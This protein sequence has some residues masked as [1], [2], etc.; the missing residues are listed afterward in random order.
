[1]AADDIILPD[2]TRVPRSLVSPEIASTY[3]SPADQAVL[4]QT[5]D[6]ALSSRF[7]QSAPPPAPAAWDNNPGAFGNNIAQTAKDVGLDYAKVLIN[8]LEA[9]KKAVAGWGDIAELGGQADKYLMEKTGGLLHQRLPTAEG[10]IAMEQKLRGTTPPPPGQPSDQPPP[11][12]PSNTPAGQVL[13]AALGAG[14]APGDSV[15]LRASPGI[16]VGMGSYADEK[17]DM[18]A[19]AGAEQ[20]AAQKL[21]DIAAQRA[22]VVAGEQQGRM[23]A[24]E[25]EETRRQAI[26]QRAQSIS[27]EQIQKA[28]TLQD[29]LRKMATVKVDPNHFWADKGTGDRMAAAFGVFLGGL[30]GGEN[31]ALG[32]L[33]RAIDRD[34]DAQKTNWDNARQIKAQEIEGQKNIYGMHLAAL[35]D[36]RAAEAGARAASLEMFGQRLEAAKSTFDSPEIKARAEAAQAAIQK[37]LAKTNMEL[38]KAVND[39]AYK[40]GTLEL[41]SAELGIRAQEANARAQAAA[42]EGQAKQMA[43]YVPGVGLALDEKSKEKVQEIAGAYNETKSALDEMRRLRKDAGGGE[44]LNRDNVKKMHVAQTAFIGAANRMQRFGSLDKGAQELLSL[45][46][47]GDITDFGSAVDGALEQA[48]TSLQ[49]S[50]Q[51]QTRPYMAQYEEAAKPVSSFVARK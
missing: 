45:L 12:G 18:S 14:G 15:S 17:R 24:M 31:Q 10:L 8:P 27:Q 28:A 30:G 26:E 3:G 20:S 34:I 19:A 42:R 47:G 44:V 46:S 9:A 29:E 43:T 49:N 41:Q 48:G 40:R 51:G 36:E 5:N 13:Q 39:D 6:A 11:P 23:R 32:I 7:G 16:R 4:S 2:G 25:Q 35:G 22:A 37:E 21:G 33:N 38:Q 1:M 50:F